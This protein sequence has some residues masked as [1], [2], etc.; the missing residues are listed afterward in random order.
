MRGSW[1]I[2]VLHVDRCSAHYRLPV[3]P[4]KEDFSRDESIALAQVGINLAMAMKDIFGSPVMSPTSIDPV[5]Q[6][7]PTQVSTE[8]E[9]LHDEHFRV[10][11]QREPCPSPI[12]PSAS[13]KVS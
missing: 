3:I 8:E 4:N 10:H 11:S 2:S 5:I 6:G 7:E 13:P 9:D 1:T 12:A